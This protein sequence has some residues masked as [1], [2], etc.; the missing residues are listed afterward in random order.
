M[1][2][3]G[4]AHQEF[5]RTVLT[6]LNLTEDANK[7]FREEATYAEEDL[8]FNLSEEEFENFKSD[9]DAHLISK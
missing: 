3:I 5:A 1:T 6:S 8:V 4:F 2:A 7:F 9:F